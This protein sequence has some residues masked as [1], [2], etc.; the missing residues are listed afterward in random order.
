M[1]GCGK[2]GIRYSHGPPYSPDLN[3]IEHLW[4]YLKELVYKIYPELLLMEGGAEP[5]KAALKQAII[6]A[7]ET[8]PERK[9]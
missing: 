6:K 8:L 7:S 4:F 9:P 3:L 2:W 5:R 1:N